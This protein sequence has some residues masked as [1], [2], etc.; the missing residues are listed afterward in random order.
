VCDSQ[1]KQYSQICPQLTKDLIHLNSNAIHTVEFTNPFHNI[2]FMKLVSNCTRAGEKRSLDNALGQESVGGTTYTKLSRCDSASTQISHKKSNTSTLPREV[3]FRTT[4]KHI[5]LHNRTMNHRNK[6]QTSLDE[7]SNANSSPTQTNEDKETEVYS[8]GSLDQSLSEDSMSSSSSC[9]DDISSTA[10]GAYDNLNAQGNQNANSTDP[11]IDATNKE[12]DMNHLNPHK[13]PT[14]MS[15]DAFLVELFQCM[16]QFRPS[17]RPTL[18]LSPLTYNSKKDLFIQPITDEELANYDVEVVTATRDEDI[19]TLRTLHSNGR[20]LSCCNRYGESLMHM[21]CRRGFFPIVDFLLHEADVSIRITDD[22]GRTPMHD[23]FWHRECQY[24][25]VDLLIRLD[26]SLLLL[27]DKRG[28]TPFAY[29]RREHWEV[30]KQF[31]WDRRQHMMEAM[32][33]DVMELFRVKI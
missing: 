19:E 12:Q 8:R 10:S 23:A 22:C 29:A 26:P 6:E 30:W 31:L 2:S 16:L 21:A 28:H 11:E 13:Y 25:I 15:P 33:M 4:S 3:H 24:S 7:Q 27:R 32:D 9:Y 1:Q 18:E 17:A 14:D 5:P 20:S